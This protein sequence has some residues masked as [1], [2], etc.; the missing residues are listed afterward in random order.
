[1]ER[2][3]VTW[4]G[5][6][7][8][9]QAG[10]LKTMP[11]GAWIRLGALSVG[12]LSAAWF[13]YLL[14]VFPYNG[15]YG[16]DAYAYAGQS[17]AL[18]DELTGRPVPSGAL[19][20]GEG[21]SHWPV[22]YHLL[23]V[24]GRLMSGGSV[25]GGRVLTLALAVL[26]P[27]LTY[28]LVVRIA[29]LAS[30]TARFA[31]G[32]TAAGSLLLIGT[33]TRTGTSLMSDVPALFFVLLALV[34]TVWRWPPEGVGGPT[35][36]DLFWAALAGSSLGLAVLIRYP[37]VLAIP[38]IVVYLMGRRLQVR[39]G[40]TRTPAI[41][42]ASLWRVLAGMLA[43]GVALAPQALYLLTHNDVSSAASF[44]A[45]LTPANL[46]SR[47][48]T[49]PDGREVFQHTML[50]FYGFSPLWDGSGGFIPAAL[51]PIFLL[52]LLAV[53]LRKSWSILALLATW[54]L[55]PAIVFAL[56]PYQAHRLALLYLPAAAACIG[57]GVGA[58]LE[59]GLVALR[60]ETG[61]RKVSAVLFAGIVALFLT[62]G[63]VQGARSVRNWQAT[64]AAWQA[65]DEALARA[66]L[67]AAGLGGRAVC[68]PSCVPV[69][70]YAG[71]PVQDMYNNDEKDLAAFIRPGAT[72]AAVT[73]RA[74]KTQWAGTA[75]AT[76]WEW[77]A[78]NYDLRWAGSSGEYTIYRVEE[79]SQVLR[80]TSTTR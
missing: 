17:A 66:V 47:S 67:D 24:I 39:R 23:L 12:V 50:E 6:C 42:T 57:I 43:F 25:V 1:M 4:F 62:A 70:F 68:L 13:A 73:E 5:L 80:R 38:P 8:R 19:F 31:A 74:L 9:V 34:T 79:R 65:E 16:V 40:P 56:T 11:D 10:N 2:A 55:L 54:W 15:L 52:G 27:V 46:L 18:L 3:I 26:V 76:R 59:V 60:R 48:S 72:A 69:D 61:G 58:V 63:M 30:L 22:G 71:L 64:H 7:R 45:T 78:A 32:S 14:Y 28:L 20:T 33:F 51:F 44:A 35:G 37:S 49:G 75:V 77:L 21:L 41:S 29:P 53:V 36:R